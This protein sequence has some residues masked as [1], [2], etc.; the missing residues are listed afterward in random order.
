MQERLPPPQLPGASDP[1]GAVYLWPPHK[2]TAFQH[3]KSVPL[4]EGTASVAHTSGR[5]LISACRPALFWEGSCWKEQPSALLGR[6]VT[7]ADSDLCS[8]FIFSESLLPAE[9]ASD[10]GV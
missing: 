8:H 10:F 9:D 5:H 2:W 1:S 3:P 4:T 7:L 6:L